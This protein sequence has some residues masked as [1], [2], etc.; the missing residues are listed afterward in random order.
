[1]PLYE[2]GWNR[3]LHFIVASNKLC[4]KFSHLFKI[5]RY[6]G[7]PLVNIFFHWRFVVRNEADI[8]AYF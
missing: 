6:Y 8:L 7:Y 5:G 2:F 4:R 1:M 3:N